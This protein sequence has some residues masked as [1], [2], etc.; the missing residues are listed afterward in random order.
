MPAPRL[1]LVTDAQRSHL[2]LPELADAA[3]Q[4][5]VD[6]IYLRDLHLQCD[7]PLQM[8]T[9]VRQRI[10]KA[11]PIMLPS[12]L[13][14]I[15]ITEGTGLHLRER[16][17]HPQA[18]IRPL[19]RAVHSIPEAVRPFGADFLLAGH[20][21]STI[22]H[23]DRPPLGI[24]GFAAI[25]AASPRPVLA[26]GGITAARVPE[27][28]AAGAHG[29]AVIG[30]IAAADDPRAAAQE[31]RQ[32]LNLA[33]HRIQELHMTDQLA[34][35][36]IVVNGKQVSV[37]A[38]ATI[39]DFLASKKMTDA[40]AIVEQN[41]EIIARARYADTLLRAGDQLEVVHAVG[42]G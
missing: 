17:P 34:A 8:I 33:I 1:L 38:S 30:A 7:T 16:D 2:P 29:V 14:A 25:A 41:G 24:P 3:V 23:P 20:C 4:G 22:S 5:G 21:F 42:G 27:V 10:G 15:A 36:E 28:I 6:A 19:S 13:A 32:A 40:M 31:L 26:I 9:A 35:I 18:P 12:E 37:P 39:H 11:V